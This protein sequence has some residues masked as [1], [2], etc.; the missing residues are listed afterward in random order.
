MND[1]I[2]TE[3]YK[4][5]KIEIHMDSDFFNPRHEFDHVGV[6]AC[7]HKRYQLGD[8]AEVHNL[9]HEGFPSWDDMEKYIRKEMDAVLVLPIYMYDHSGLT[10]STTPFSCGWDSGQI[11]FIYMTRKAICDNWSCKRIGKKIL[12]KAEKSC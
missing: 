8:K 3:T 6:M 10:I 7:F 1:A 11:G 12:E 9:R 5:Y 2:S 4:G